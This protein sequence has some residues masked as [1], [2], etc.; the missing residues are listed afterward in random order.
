MATSDDSHSLA[1]ESLSVLHWIG[2]GLALVTAL[3]HLLLGIG[4][5]PHW[6][7]AAFLVA[8]AGF[9]LGI[10]FVLIDYRRRTVYLLGIPFTA[11]QIVLWYVVNQPASVGDLS[12]AGAVDKV[13]QALLLVVLVVLYRRE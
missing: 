2:I 11:A 5:L 1:L 8:T 4:F 3:V 9:C 7:G 10:A 13:A 6:M 12:V